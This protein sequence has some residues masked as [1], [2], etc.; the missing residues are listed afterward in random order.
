MNEY[1]GIWVIGEIQAG[2]LGA[3]TSELLGCGR[4]LAEELRQELCLVLMGEN[5]S[6]PANEGILLGADRVFTIEDSNLSEYRTN[7][8]VAAIANLYGQTRPRIILLGQTSCGR[9][10]A[11]KLAFRLETVAEMDCIDLT[12]DHETGFLL[13]T[14]PVYGGSARGVFTS[15]CL[16]QI[17]TVRAK[18]MPAAER[19][20]S[21]TGKIIPVESGLDGAEIGTR[22]LERRKQE[23]EGLKLEDAD[24][25]I[26][27]GRGIGGPEGFEEL[28]KL[29]VLLKG[30][31]G[32]T[33]PPCDSEW[34]PNTWL[35]GLTGKIIVP[36]L[37]IAVAVS[38]A[39]QHMSG[40]ATSKNIVAIN[41]D[42]EA[43]IFREARYGVVG[44]WKKVLPAFTQKVKELRDD[45]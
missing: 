38:G 36:D 9:D 11:P 41:K 8:F 44:D 1:K 43:N 6:A 4:K 31:V 29:A 23:T 42:E 7:A 40:C 21:R 13:Q 20:E 39:S 22:I 32:A 2:K 12:I 25:V 17:A 10:L 45:N 34:V 35:I 14:R 27:G 15:E 19:D 37:Y 5:L 18:T 24:V 16:P 28:E 30:A 26:G 3:I 33:R